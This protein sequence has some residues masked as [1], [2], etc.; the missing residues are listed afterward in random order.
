M[1]GGVKVRGL[2]TGRGGPL[3][4]LDR[5]PS[6]D[7]PSFRPSKDFQTLLD[8]KKACSESRRREM[9]KMLRE[10]RSGQGGRGS[11]AGKTRGET[12]VIPPS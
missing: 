4:A 7:F 11:G 3:E 8:E 12:P 9:S 6:R 5:R 1:G 2:G 10:A